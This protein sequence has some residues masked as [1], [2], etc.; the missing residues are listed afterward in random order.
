MMAESFLAN[1]PSFK[2]WWRS[3]RKRRYFIRHPRRFMGRRYSCDYGVCDFTAQ[4][5]SF[6]SS[7]SCWGTLRSNRHNLAEAM[8]VTRERFTTPSHPSYLSY[9]SCSYED[10]DGDQILS[11]WLYRT[12]I[13]RR[14]P[15]FNFGDPR[16]REYPARIRRPTLAAGDGSRHQETGQSL[17]VQVR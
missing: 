12:A 8:Q 6:V 5:M 3:L 1:G 9:L 13:T 17:S 11:Q 2:N 16:S 15:L 7:P 10:E 4:A 14:S